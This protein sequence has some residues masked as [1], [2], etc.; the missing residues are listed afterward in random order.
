M[1]W[2]RTGLDSDRSVLW[3]FGLGFGCCCPAPLG[4]I[5]LSSQPLCGW[6][7]EGICTRMC[8]CPRN[9]AF[10]GDFLAD[11]KRAMRKMVALSLSCYWEDVVPT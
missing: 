7:R 3:F 6:S 11:A 9:V 10:P 5:A 8:L 1:P 4:V 2:D